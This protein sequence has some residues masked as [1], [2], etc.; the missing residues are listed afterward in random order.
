M[1][2]RQ[3]V[4]AI[5]VCASVAPGVQ[6]QTPAPSDK[7]AAIEELLIVIGATKTAKQIFV[8]LIEQYSQALAYD[9]VQSLENKNW[10]PAV[11]VKAKEL[12]QDFHNRLS[13]RLR[14]EL[15]QR[16][17]YEEK[18]SRLYV[19]VFDEHFTEAE[20]NEL[21]VFYRG[22]LGQKFLTLPA[23]VAAMFQQ[24]SKMEIEPAILNTTRT[25]VDE[26]VKQLEE[27]AARELKTPTPRK[28]G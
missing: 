2:F 13:Q 16:I 6:A 27:R 20:V 1:F 14:E 12:S 17:N 28:K 19:D 5:V 11:K 25:I 23:K 9:S 8:T 10:P 3:L 24:K 7:R 21:L 22:P 26:E 4:L 18:A 15:P